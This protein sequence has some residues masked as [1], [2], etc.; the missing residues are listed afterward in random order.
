MES[1]GQN[2]RVGSLFL[3]QG[4][5]SNPGI[6]PRSPGLQA[7]SLPAEQKGSPKKLLE[8]N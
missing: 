7:D 1:L 2:T 8:E 3:L 5:L 4:N 6:K